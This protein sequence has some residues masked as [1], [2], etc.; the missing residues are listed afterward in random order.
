MTCLLQ[1][2]LALV[3]LCNLL[4]E[5]YLLSFYSPIGFKLGSSR[6]PPIDIIAFISFYTFCANNPH[7]Q[8]HI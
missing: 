2:T 3:P 5:R 6:N 4:L 8:L 1:G 7:K